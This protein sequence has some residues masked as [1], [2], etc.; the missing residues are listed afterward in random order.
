M[1]QATDYEP[2]FAEN[3]KV[4][5]EI[6]QA[7]PDRFPIILMDVS[8]PV[9]DGYMATRAIRDWEIKEGRVPVPIIAL[10]GHAAAT[11]KQDCRDA[12]MDAFLTKPVKQSELLKALNVYGQG[13]QSARLA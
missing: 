12:G 7:E 9:M 3:G 4:A 1:L 5:L 13:G 6:F 10:T 8:M 11:D 2:I